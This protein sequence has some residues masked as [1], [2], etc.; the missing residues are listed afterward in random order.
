MREIAMRLHPSPGI[1]WLDDGLP[2]LHLVRDRAPFDLV[3]MTAVWMHLDEA[4]RAQAMPNVMA[5]LAPRG[6][7]IMTLRHGPVPPGRRMFEVSAAETIKLATGLEVLLNEHR[8][9]L[10]RQISDPNVSWTQ[11]A[12]RKP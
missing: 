2:E 6:V 1:E 9:S 11:L 8:A 4:Q 3:L 12:L 7:L 10:R 5:L